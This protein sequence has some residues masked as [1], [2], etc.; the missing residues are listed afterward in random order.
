VTEVI[1]KPWFMARR[2]NG[3]I[4]R[5]LPSPLLQKSLKDSE[6]LALLA[7]GVYQILRTRIPA[8]AAIGETVEAAKQLNLAHTAGLLNAVLRR[9]IQEQETLM[10]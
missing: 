7:I 6:V 10:R 1:A 5:L 2:V 4:F 9:F 8:H 3:C